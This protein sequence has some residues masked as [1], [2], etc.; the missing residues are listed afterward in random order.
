MA[1]LY[2]I[3]RLVSIILTR[4]PNFLMKRPPIRQKGT[5]LGP[6]RLVCCLLLIHFTGA[7][8]TNRITGMRPSSHFISPMGWVYKSCC[9]NCHPSWHRHPMRYFFF[10]PSIVLLKLIHVSRK[11]L[12]IQVRITWIHTQGQLWIFIQ[13]SKYM[14]SLFHMHLPWWLL[15]M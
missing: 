3:A 7:A 8:F 5:H 14:Q 15:E 1:H 6:D 11:Y 13:E 9:L 12:V 2:A 10:C 4:R